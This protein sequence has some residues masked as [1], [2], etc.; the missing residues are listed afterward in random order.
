MKDEK[1]RLFLAIN[2]EERIKA[3][4]AEVTE[5]LKAQA[6]KGTFTK[7]QNLHLTLVFLGVISQK[8]FPLIREAMDEVNVESFSLAM[9]DFGKFKT[10]GGDIYW[11][12]FEENESLKRLYRQLWKALDKRGFDVEEREYTPHLTLGRQVILP[13][14]FNTQQFRDTVPKQE[15]M[16][17]KIS[18]M[19]SERINGILTYTEIQDKELDIRV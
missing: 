6:V 14:D 16:V 8:R 10:G 7:K 5:R 15:V 3:S 1:L 18:L 13:K 12:G 9:Q 19:K 2:F 11:L 4:V 17:K